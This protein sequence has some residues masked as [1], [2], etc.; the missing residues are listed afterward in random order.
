MTDLFLPY[1]N[2]ERIQIMLPKMPIFNSSSDKNKEDV[3]ELEKELNINLP[4]SYKEFLLKGYWADPEPNFFRTKYI[5]DS[6]YSFHRISSVINNTLNSWYEEIEST[7][8]IPKTMIDIATTPL[9]NSI[10]LGVKDETY[11]KIYFLNYS[12]VEQSDEVPEGEPEIYLIADSFEEFIN[13]FY[14]E[15]ELNNTESDYEDRLYYHIQ[16]K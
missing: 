14:T 11:N 8:I 13:S 9:D 12:G 2:D 7:L 10:L 5:G 1:I 15:E 4:K 3:D 6:I 16:K